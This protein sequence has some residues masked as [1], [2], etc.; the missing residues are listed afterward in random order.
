[1]KAKENFIRCKKAL[2]EIWHLNRVHVSKEMS[3][4]YRLLKKYFVNLKIMGFNTGKKC[5]DWVVPPS[6]DVYKATLKDPK[7][8]VIADYSKNKLSLW[9]NSGSFKGKI[10]KKKLENKILSNPEKPE[11]TTFHFRNQYNFW[12]KNGVFL[13]LTNY[14]KILRKVNIR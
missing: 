6:W 14:T 13:Y 4:A 2:K 5:G 1:M 7:G 10:D 8:K 11:A 12:K 3:L 9:T